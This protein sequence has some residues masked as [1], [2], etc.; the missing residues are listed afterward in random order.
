MD[1]AM[2]VGAKE[3]EIVQ[4]GYG[5]TSYAAEGDKVVHLEARV[6]NIGG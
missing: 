3:G 1:H 5:L 2:T 6:T 4:T